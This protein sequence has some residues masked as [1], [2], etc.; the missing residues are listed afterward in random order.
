MATVVGAPGMVIERMIV[1]IRGM[2]G[3]VYHLNHVKVVMAVAVAVVVV[4]VVEV[5]ETKGNV[6]HVAQQNTGRKNAPSTRPSRQQ[7]PL[8]TSHRTCAL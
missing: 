5:V 6:G 2:V 3:N 4:E 1:C 8:T 7:P